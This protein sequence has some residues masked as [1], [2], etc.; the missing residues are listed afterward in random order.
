M[1]HHLFILDKLSNINKVVGKKQGALNLFL[2][3]VYHAGFK[4]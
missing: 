3:D 2:V 4:M 1:M